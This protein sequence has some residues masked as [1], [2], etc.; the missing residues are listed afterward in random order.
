M[1]RPLLQL[2]IVVSAGF[3]AAMA[4]FPALRLARKV[5]AAVLAVV[6]ALLTVAP[7]FISAEHS[8]AL[9][10]GAA[11]DRV[12][13]EAVRSACGWNRSRSAKFRCVLRLPPQP[14]F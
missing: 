3:A 1:P 10:G 13:R 7:L 8:P 5:R 2:L 4:F 9:C 6:I 11:F 12:G 14:R